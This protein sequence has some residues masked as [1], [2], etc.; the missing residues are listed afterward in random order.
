MEEMTIMVIIWLALKLRLPK[1]MILSDTSRDLII[2]KY[3]RSRLVQKLALCAAKEKMIYS[4]ID[5]NIMKYSAVYVRTKSISL[6]LFISLSM[7]TINSLTTVFNA[8]NLT[9]IKIS[10]QNYVLH[11]RHKLQMFKISSGLT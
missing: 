11:I 3:T 7:M 10:F 6:A 1:K 5:I 4:L 8:C 2:S 9:P